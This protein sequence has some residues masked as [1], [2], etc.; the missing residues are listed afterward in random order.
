MAQLVLTMDPQLSRLGDGELQRRRG[1]DQKQ[2]IEDKSAIVGNP[3]IVPPSGEAEEGYCQGDRDPNEP[4]TTHERRTQLASGEA[5]HVSTS[6]GGLDELSRS[7]W[8]ERTVSMIR[9]GMMGAVKCEGRACVVAPFP[10]L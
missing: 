3:L 7:S 10:S 9:T 2:D 8:S 5:Q 1:D 6:D 4:R